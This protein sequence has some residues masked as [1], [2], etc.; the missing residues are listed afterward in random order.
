MD[1]STTNAFSAGQSVPLIIN[2]KKVGV[3]KDGVLTK[4]KSQVVL[5]KKY[6]GFAMSKQILD[7]PEIKKIVLEYAEDGKTYE[8][9][10]LQFAQKGIDYDNYGDY[11]LVLPRKYWTQIDP[12]QA[13]LI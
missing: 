5:F 1:E 10:P 11:Q 8:T 3:L 9:T 12:N 6:D 4:K 2:G 7:M 13:T